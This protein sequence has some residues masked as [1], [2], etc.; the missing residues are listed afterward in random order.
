MKTIFDIID[1][2]YKGLEVVKKNYDDGNFDLAKR[3]LINY[4]RTRKHVKGFLGDKV[5]LSE[6]INENKSEEV[7]HILDMADDF[8]NKKII[9][10]MKW[11]MERCKTPYLFEEDIIWDIVPFEDPEWTYMLNRHRYFI[12]YGQSYLIT[13]DR[14]YIEAFKDQIKSWISTAEQLGTEN[15]LIYRTIEAGLRCRNWIKSLEY[16]IEDE[17][18]DD[19]LIELMLI[20]INNHIEFITKSTKEDRLLSNWVILEQ[21]GVFIASTYFPEL[22]VSSKLRHKSLEIIEKA[23]EIQILDDG[24]Q[25]EQSYMYHNEMLNCM[26]DVAIIASRNNIELS[27]YMLEKIKKMSYATLSFMRPDYKQSNYGDSDE[28]DLRDILGLASVVLKDGQLKYLVRNLDL[29]SILNIGIEGI[30][31]FENIKPIEPNFKN[32]AHESSGNYI[33]RNKWGE[34]GTYT[35]FKCGPI[36]SGHGHFD[37]LHFDI[38]HKGENYIVD[39]GRYNYGE[40]CEYRELL[41][42][43][44][45]HNATTVDDKEFTISRGSWGSSKV[46]YPI[47]R[48]YSFKNIASFVE[49]SHL[50]YFDIGVFTTRKLIYIKPSIWIISDEFMSHGTHKYK[51]Y[52]NF[53]EDKLKVYEDRV[54]YNGKNGDLTILPISGQSISVE[55]AYISK[56]YNS[57]YKS[58]KCILE[59]IKEGTTNLNSILYIDD[60]IKIKNVEYVDIINWRK[61]VLDKQYAQAIK[62]TLEDTVYIVVVVH[63]EEPKG[64]R[65]YTIEN[66]P[67]YGRV[68]VIKIKDDTITKEVLAY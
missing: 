51:S 16:F 44:I 68:G 47:K 22:K 1:L 21:H 23:L 67:F 54:I 42:K 60:E 14:K 20:N 63:E 62:I 13:K 52:F 56:E 57:I 24:L 30:Q 3:E 59:S 4:F 15:K 66:I 28:E 46:A 48:D 38:N 18:I 25:W 32:V 37:L 41:K 10:D 36:G 27:S 17:I 64:R 7:R 39:S 40:D 61:E 6:Y 34:D 29:E 5:L 45:S 55:D 49:G 26:L 31:V 65:N 35:F 53:E 33:L 9:Y 58:K 12:T 2:N 8:S 50:G 43:A 11:D 19:S